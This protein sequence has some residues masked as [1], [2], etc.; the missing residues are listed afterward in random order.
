MPLP[1]QYAVNLRTGEVT[2]FNLHSRYT[3]SAQG[4][5]V[6]RQSPSLRLTY[7][8]DSVK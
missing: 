2:L 5:A 3:F 8:Y 7:P 4:Y 6:A 1:A